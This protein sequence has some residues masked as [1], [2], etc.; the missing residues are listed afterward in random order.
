MCTPA[1]EVGTGQPASGR[2]V[3]DKG[4]GAGPSCGL[5]RPESLPGIQINRFEVIPK[6]HQPGKWHL[7]VD[8]SYSVGGSDSDGIELGFIHC[9]IRW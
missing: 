4:G 1:R 3:S 9:T 8:L 2:P 6:S 5:H 7:I